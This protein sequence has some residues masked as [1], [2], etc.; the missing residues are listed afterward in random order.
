MRLRKPASVLPVKSEGPKNVTATTNSTVPELGRRHGLVSLI[1]LGGLLLLRF[2]FLIAADMLLARESV[3]R[4]V[5]VGIFAGGTYLLTAVLI[6]WER[7]RLQDFW[8]DIGSGITFLCQ[9]FCF[10]IGIVLFRAMRRSQARFPP[11][12]PGVLP[13]LLIGPILALAATLLTTRLGLEPIR[14]RGQEAASLFWL[15][16]ST[17]IQMNVA[18]VLEE[19]L[20]RGFLWGYLRRWHW[21]NILIWLLQAVLFTLAH[22]YYL[23]DESFMPWL[24]RIML[25]SLVIGLVAWQARSIFA[26]MVTHGVFNASA[27]ILMHARSFTEAQNVC[28]IAL[29]ALA[30]LLVSRWILK[31]LR[32]GMD[33]N[34]RLHR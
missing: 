3:Y 15:L 1:L 8:I 25:P 31:R 17:F 23:K 6:W 24:I 2:P 27:D 29:L 16:T 11:L 14:P 22:V 28:W 4:T 18:A 32:A 26:S 12:P 19:P 30:G 13:W 7:E 5:S 34:A 10:P 9:I 33:K 21:S 20:F